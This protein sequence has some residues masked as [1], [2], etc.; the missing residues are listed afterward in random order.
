VNVLC[1]G[2][3]LET[4]PLN[5]AYEETHEGAIL[6]HQGET[7]RSDELDLVNLIA[8][9][10]Q[11]ST[12]YY[13]ETQKTVEVAIKKTLEETQKDLKTSLGEL[14]ITENY[15][16]YV[17]K[18]NDVIIK[19]HTLDLPSSSFSTVGLWFTVPEQIR[20]EIEDKGLNF[21]GG[22]HA[23]EHAIIAMAPM[24]A[25]CDRWDI[26][27]MSTAEHVDTGKPTI[28][29]Y[30]GFEGG[31]GISENLYSNIKPLLE[32]TLQLIETCECKEGCPSCIYSPKCGNGNEPLDKKAA[33]FILQRLI[34]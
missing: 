23:L 24:F 16:S 4:L 25:M 29:I 10:R 2:H 22:L 21:E 19:K 8:T 33:Y 5:K 17:V 26:G 9:V 27:G 34:E 14:T 12:N 20:E 6:L 32:K 30:D 1:N 7:Y 15:P 3:I 31:I 28:F 18:A 11:E 13:T